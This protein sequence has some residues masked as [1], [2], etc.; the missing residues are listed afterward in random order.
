MRVGDD[1]RGV[2]RLPDGFDHLDLVAGKSRNGS[3]I[4]LRR[5]DALCFHRGQASCK[6]RFTDER[7][8][9]ALIESRNARPFAGAF[10]TG[11]V[12]NFLDD[13]LSVGILVGKNIAG[14][15]N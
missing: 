11:S 15:L 4:F 14:D 7:Q 9:D 2:K 10:L 5:L 12:K 8:R 1:L 3:V 13:G 6:D